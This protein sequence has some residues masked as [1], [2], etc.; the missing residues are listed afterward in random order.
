VSYN[1]K[2]AV[3]SGGPYETIANVGTTNY[4]EDNLSYGT[5][6]YVVSAVDVVGEGGNSAEVSAVPVNTPVADA[7][8]YG[9]SINSNYGTDTNLIVKTNGLSFARD[10]YLMFDVSGL[11]NAQSVKLQLMPTLVNG[12]P[13]LGY[14]LVTDD[15]W[16]EAGI[17]WATT[18]AGTGI[19][20]TNQT[21]YAAG[22]PV[23]V[24]VTAVAQAQA[25]AGGDE[26]LS[27]H[28]YSTINGSSQ[29]NFGSKESLQ[30]ANQPQLVVTWPPLSPLFTNVSMVGPG[31]ITINGIG[32]S[33]QRYVLLMA[34]NLSL[35]I[36][37]T[38][39]ATNVAGI[40]RQIQFVDAKATNSVQR[41]YRLQTH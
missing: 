30:L 27:I 9:N 4:L 38:P 8:V 34:T 28:I 40:N 25:Q 13:V 16:T 18:P 3:V 15:N 22:V 31:G 23:L 19:I 6:Y 21:G 26:H 14:E 7:Y 41:L 11:D 2:R 20:L 39:I 37:W 29:V 10:S 24:D 5:Y 33:G 17:T 36:H 32:Q 12:S 1:V 35:P